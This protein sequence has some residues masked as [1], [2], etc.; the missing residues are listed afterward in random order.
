MGNPIRKLKEKPFNYIIGYVFFLL[1][2]VIGTSFQM[3]KYMTNELVLV[4]EDYWVNP[5]LVLTALFMMFVF[6]PMALVDIIQYFFKNI[7]TKKA[8]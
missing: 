5:E 1:I 4:S 3:F 6:R 2:G 7:V 8:K